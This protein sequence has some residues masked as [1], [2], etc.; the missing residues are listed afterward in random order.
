M[1]EEEKRSQ[2]DGQH[3][4]CLQ[5]INQILEA[6]ERQSGAPCL[7]LANK[8]NSQPKLEASIGREGTQPPIVNDWESPFIDACIDDMVHFLN[9]LP[10]DSFF[11]RRYFAVLDSA[12][13]ADRLPMLH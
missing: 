13:E 12:F 9:R 5:T 10:K 1:Q 3:S 11:N 8:K 7:W 4:G 2:D 6:N